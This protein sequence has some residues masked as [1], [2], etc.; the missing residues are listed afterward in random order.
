MIESIGAVN[1]NLIDEIVE[2]G[3]AI[4]RI[5]VVR[6]NEIDESPVNL[7]QDALHLPGAAT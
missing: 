2:A 5:V 3:I 6:E 7:G 4:M 1:E